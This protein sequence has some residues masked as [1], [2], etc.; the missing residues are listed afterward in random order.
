MLTHSSIRMSTNFCKH[1]CYNV[2]VNLF[3]YSNDNKRY[4]TFSFDTKNRYQEKVFK[5]GLNA[6]FTCPNRDGKKG[7]GGCRFCNALGSGDFQGNTKESLLQQFKNGIDIQRKKWPNAKA[8]AYFQAYTNTYAP[9]SHL[10]ELF[11][12]FIYND[13]AIALS[14]ATRIDCLDDEIILYLESLTEYKDVYLELGLQTTHDSIAKNMNRG[15][16]YDEFLAGYKRLENSKLKIVVHLMNGYPNETVEMM[17]ENA[18]KVG[19]LKPYG[20][21]LHM[22]NVLDDSALGKDYLKNPFKILS[23]EEYVDVIVEQ[24]AHI[25]EE[26]VILR[27]TGDYDKEHLLAPKWILNKTQVLNDIDKKMAQDNRYQGDKL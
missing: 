26:V 2:C 22:L 25:P 6:D 21:K 7:Y 18:K 15:Y 3:K 13:D 12:P 10:K 4:H 11:E 8:I 16:T 14:I 1:A 5:V 27:L 20:I 17:I 9:L 19:Q 23:E 24:L